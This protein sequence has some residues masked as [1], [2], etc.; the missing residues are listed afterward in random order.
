MTL[1]DGLVGDM[2]CVVFLAGG[3]V[4]GYL[5][6]RDSGRMRD[7]RGGWRHLPHLPATRYYAPTSCTA[8][9]SPPSISFMPHYYN[10]YTKLWLCRPASP[11]THTHL[12]GGIQ[13]ILIPAF[14]PFSVIIPACNAHP[15]PLPRLCL[16]TTLPAPWHLPLPYSHHYNPYHRYPFSP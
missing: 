8:L 9:P 12:Q 13:Y 10:H 2:I 7:R 15:F 14:L 5:R 16:P 1:G 4:G 11:T 6:G 3:D